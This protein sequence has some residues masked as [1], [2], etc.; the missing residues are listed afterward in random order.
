M[1]KLSIVTPERVFYEADV[2][3]L[4]VPGTDGYLGVLTS[5][6]PLITALQPG[7]IEFVDA[8]G[9]IHIMAVTSGFLE[10]SRNVATLLADA[11]E[12][13]SEIDIERAR[14]AH[15][16][17]WQQLKAAG[18]GELEIDMQ[19]ARAALKRAANRIRIHEQSH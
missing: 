16:K 11:A 18:R 8:E 5:H 15:D 17:A 3:S 1:F 4:I 12:D 6:A 14:A 19:E 13:V 10:V 2:R 9:A 7:K